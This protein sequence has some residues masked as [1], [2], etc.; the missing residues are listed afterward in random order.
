MRTVF[1]GTKDEE[2]KLFFLNDCGNSGETPKTHETHALLARSY[3]NG[4]SDLDLLWQYHLRHGHRNF[5]DIARQYQIPM[6]KQVSACTSCITAKSHVHP[7]LSSGFEHPCGTRF[8][9]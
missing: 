3:G 4:K 7:H 1:I 8:S 9:F 6:P 5:A 2:T